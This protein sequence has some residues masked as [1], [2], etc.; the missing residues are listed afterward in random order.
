MQKFFFND[1]E[2][3]VRTRTKPHKDGSTLYAWNITRMCYLSGMYKTK[4]ADTYRI[5]V[6]RIL[7]H[8]N[9]ATGE[10]IRIGALKPKYE[11]VP[12]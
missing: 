6:D 9:I 1:N 2:C 10:V 8:V 11:K 5:E 4:D 7:Y 3:V 12:A